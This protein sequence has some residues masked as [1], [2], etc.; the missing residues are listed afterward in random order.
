MPVLVGVMIMVSMTTFNWSSF[1][2]LKQAPKSEAFVMIITVAIILYTSNLAIGVVIGVILSALF[3]VAKISRVTVTQEENMFR[4]KGPLFFAST[5]K[6]VQSFDDVTENN[7]I[8]NLENSQLWDESAVGAI[9]K[10]K[11]KFEKKGVKVDVQ[12]LNSSSKQLYN[13][14]I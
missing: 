3:F 13:K 5:T 12:G 6:F 1:K 8:I 10:V 14:L 7:I 9:L 4:V 11:N 2:F